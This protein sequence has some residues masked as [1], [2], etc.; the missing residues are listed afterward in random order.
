MFAIISR[1]R[2][3]RLALVAVLLALITCAWGVGSALAAPPIQ[4]ATQGVDFSAL[5]GQFTALAGVGALIAAL[6][7]TLKKFGV[8]KDGDAMTWATGLNLV[9]IVALYLLRVFAPS[10][11]VG[12]VDSLAQS[13]AEILVL[14]VGVVLQLGLTRGANAILKGAPVIGYSYTEADAHAGFPRLETK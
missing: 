12:G 14:V 4:D 3:W 9:G 7:N 5:L 8:V 11:D 10:V 13:I 6:V 1:S 2:I